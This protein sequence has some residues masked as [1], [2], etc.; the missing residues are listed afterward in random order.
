[1]GTLFIFAITLCVAGR[2]LAIFGIIAAKEICNR[3]HI[4]N[5]ILMRG[6]YYLIVTQAENTP[7]TATV[8]INITQQ[9]PTLKLVTQFEMNAKHSKRRSD[10]VFKM[11][12]ICFTQAHEWKNMKSTADAGK[13]RIAVFVREVGATCS[14]QQWVFAHDASTSILTSNSDEWYGIPESDELL[15]F[16]KFD[17]WF[18]DS[19][20]HRHDSKSIYWQNQRCHQ[21]AHCEVARFPD[22]L[23]YFQ[24]FLIFFTTYSDQKPSN[25]CHEIL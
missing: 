20:V 16:V 6:I 24:R 13:R 8:D 23:S 9:N 11:S 4:S 19:L 18:C 15:S 21:C 22:A 5:F 10:Q 3:I 14:L 7:S 17:M 2:S 1:M 12:S 25:L